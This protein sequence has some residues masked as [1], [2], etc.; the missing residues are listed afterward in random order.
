[1]M[2]V[3]HSDPLA[4]NRSNACFVIDASIFSQRVDFVILSDETEI[5]TIMERLSFLVLLISLFSA[6][7]KENCYAKYF[8]HAKRVRDPHKLQSKNIIPKH[9][10]RDW[11]NITKKLSTENI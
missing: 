5:Y 1:M 11:S 7:F 3:Q 4:G 9:C 10:R 8:R 6:I 2:K